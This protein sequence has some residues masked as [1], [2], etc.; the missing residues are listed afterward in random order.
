MLTNFLG[1]LP[2]LTPPLY[3]KPFIMCSKSSPLVV[4]AH[5]NASSFPLSPVHL[6]ASERHQRSFNQQS[7]CVIP[8]ATTLL[9]EGT[10]S[11]NI[12]K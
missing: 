5:D 9:N 12:L 2:I 8:M 6:Q 11:E 10:A 4:F 3:A 7:H 1:V